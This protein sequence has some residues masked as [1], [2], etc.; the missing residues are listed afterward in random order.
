MK[1]MKK[2]LF[3]TITLSS[4]ILLTLTIAC[5]REIKSDYKPQANT[6]SLST[7]E[8]RTGNEFS[9]PSEKNP[10]VQK[11]R[12]KIATCSLDKKNLEIHCKTTV[13]S[14]DAIIHWHE[15]NTSRNDS[16]SDFRFE[17]KTPIKNEVLIRL[18]ECLKTK[19]EMT[20]IVVDT[21]DI[22][23]KTTVSSNKS[24][25]SSSNKISEETEKNHS[26][27]SH[28]SEK[29]N[30][31]NNKNSNRT[32]QSEYSQGKCNSDRTNELL[33]SPINVKSLN[34]II[35]MGHMQGNHITPIDH[36]YL[37][38]NS[39]LQHDILPMSDGDIVY[40]S[41][42]GEDYRI[43]IE[44]TCNLYSIYI[45]ISELSSEIESQAKW[46]GK[47]RQ[48]AEGSSKGKSRV[49]IP[50][51]KDQVIGYVTGRGSFDLTVVDTNIILDGF[52]KPETYKD[53]FWKIHSVDPFKYLVKSAKETLIEKT[54]IINPSMPGGK[55]DYDQKGKLIG[56]WFEKDSG[57]YSG[58]R[59]EKDPHGSSKHIS[60]A[61]SALVK[62]LPWISLGSSFTKTYNSGLGFSIK[63]YTERFE[64]ISTTSGK[65]KFELI[66]LDKGDGTKSGYKISDTG[67][68]WDEISYPSG[69]NLSSI[70]RNE[71]SMIM[72]IEIL[73]DESLKIETFNNTTL[74]QISDFTDQAKI[75]T[76]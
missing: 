63:N 30:N 35:P 23:T 6:T 14:K 28:N 70:F 57:G 31:H 7:A 52:I 37:H 66:E 44:Y 56:N 21:S 13:N 58:I 10:A 18:E 3:A 51:T 38:Y 32:M 41:D 19:C 4:I 16:G 24:H 25:P 42:T 2:Y 55:I 75:Y 36:M 46:D 68:L 60:F 48:F 69:G 53:E 26:K 72:M 33:S 71:I 29:L 59:T 45:H 12:D 39:S 22:A 17:L 65:V 15:N 49:R 64:N 40:I 54:I 11:H 27:P 74:D 73:N 62:D 67:T 50:V 1:I 9:N 8:A 61:Y 20:E 43:V 76:R 47:D 34:V 5:G